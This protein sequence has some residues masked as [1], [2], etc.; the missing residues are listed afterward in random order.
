MIC[1]IARIRNQ[2][3]K[4]MNFPFGESDISFRSNLKNSSIGKL[5]QDVVDAIIQLKPYKGGNEEL[6][7]LHDLD[8]LDKH[9]LVIPSTTSKA[10]V[11]NYDRLVEITGDPTLS[12]VLPMHL[13]PGGYVM[14]RRDIPP[15]LVLPTE[16][17]PWRLVFYVPPLRYDSGKQEEFPFSGQ[18]LVPVLDRLTELTGEIV[19][20]FQ[21][22]FE[23]PA[24]ADA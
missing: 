11:I 17:E 14:A 9:K 4:K 13:R 15:E 19:R 2:S 12:S 18:R 10:V 6:K 8:I 5:G 23:R 22:Q 21:Q 20:S 16:M 1:D 24:L 3:T 7:G